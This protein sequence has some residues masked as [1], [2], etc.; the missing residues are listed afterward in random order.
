MVEGEDN[1]LRGYLRTETGNNNDDTDGLLTDLTDAPR[2]GGKRGKVYWT[3][4]SNITLPGRPKSAYALRPEDYKGLMKTEETCKAGLPAKFRLDV[5]G[6]N[7]NVTLT[8]WINYIH[9]YME[10]R[11]MDRVFRILNASTTSETYLL[12]N[13]FAARKNFYCGRLGP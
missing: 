3:G 13:W 11:G 9:K 1:P 2:I 6:K 8:S 7:T 4:G 12:E 10:E 5:S